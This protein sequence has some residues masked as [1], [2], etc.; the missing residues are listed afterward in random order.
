VHPSGYLY[1]RH[2]EWNAT[3]SIQ[4]VHFVDE[5]IQIAIQQRPEVKDIVDSCRQH[6]WELVAYLVN[7][8]RVEY[9]VVDHRARR[10][11]TPDKVESKLAKYRARMQN[12]PAAQTALNDLGLSN[13]GKSVSC[14]V[15]KDADAEN[16]RG[17]YCGR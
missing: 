15:V 6:K 5:Q 9:L 1:F 11:M 2:E 4:P 10:V 7:G 17:G 13:I 3:T 16:D 14:E 12:Q 8:D